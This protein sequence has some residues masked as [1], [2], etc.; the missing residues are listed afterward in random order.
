MKEVKMHKKVSIAEMSL[1]MEVHLSGK[2]KEERE[3][4]EKSV[5]VQSR[6]TTYSGGKRVRKEAYSNK[7]WLKTSQT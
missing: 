5:G 3:G 2:K 6:V 1:M 7:Y 4:M